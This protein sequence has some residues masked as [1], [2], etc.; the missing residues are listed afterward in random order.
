MDAPASIVGESIIEGLID[1]A[2]KTPAGCFVEVG[3]YKGGTGWHLAKLAEK[4][5]REVFLFDTFTGLPYKGPF[6]PMTTGT[7]N[8]T[9]FDEVKR[10][11]PYAQVIQ[12]IFPQS[13]EEQNISLPPVAFVHLDCDQYQSIKESAQFLTPMMVSGGVMWFDDYNCLEGATMAVDE[14]F[15][16]R[17]ETSF[18]GKVF[19][20]F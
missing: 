12:G 8:D 11:I 1:L 20:R 15:R 3:V 4:Q 5:K 7:F 6:D 19:V 16:G 13:V 18:V 9:S 10:I 17:I 2:R 14:L